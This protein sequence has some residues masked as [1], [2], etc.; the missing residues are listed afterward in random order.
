MIYLP[1][2][3]LNRGMTAAQ[4]MKCMHGKD[5]R[6]ETGFVMVCIF[7]AHA[8]ALLEGVALLE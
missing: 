5:G 1:E 6:K 4:R 8:V 2:S 7:L 3:E